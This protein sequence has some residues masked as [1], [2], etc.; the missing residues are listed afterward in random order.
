MSII[1]D[2][3]YIW[4]HYKANRKLKSL[5]E[6]NKQ[7]E[8]FI[9]DAIYIEINGDFNTVYTNLIEVCEYYHKELSPYNKR[10]LPDNIGTDINQIPVGI[11]YLTKADTLIKINSTI[12]YLTSQLNNPTFKL[13]P[14]EVEKLNTNY[15]RYSPNIIT[16]VDF[17]DKMV[18]LLKTLKD[19]KDSP[20]IYFKLKPLIFVLMSVIV[21][22]SKTLYEFNKVEE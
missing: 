4:K 9:N 14:L 10:I 3:F 22:S 8:S 5:M 17:F 1:K 13:K 6:K 2:I 19:K 15:L 7:Y 16:I 18:N 12:G 21:V 11:K 20:L